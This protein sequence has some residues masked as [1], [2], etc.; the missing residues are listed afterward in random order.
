MFHGDG[1]KFDKPTECKSD[2]VSGKTRSTDM[3][4]MRDQSREKCGETF[5]K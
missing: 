4:L 2:I 3:L 5:M 1:A